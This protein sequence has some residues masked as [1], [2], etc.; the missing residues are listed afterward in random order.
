MCVEKP[1]QLSGVTCYEGN[2]LLRW[3]RLSNLGPLAIWNQKSS[4][5]T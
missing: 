1:G 2:V 5:F 3:G 4:M